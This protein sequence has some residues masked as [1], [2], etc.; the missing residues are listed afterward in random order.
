MAG[1]IDPKELV[2]QNKG[3]VAAYVLAL[4]PV[5]LHASVLILIIRRHR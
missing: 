1:A 5:I 4:V 2:L 3:L